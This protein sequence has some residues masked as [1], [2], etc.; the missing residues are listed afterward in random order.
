ML[1]VITKLITN[2][3]K[4]PEM[5]NPLSIEKL[6]GVQLINRHAVIT[7]A[8]SPAIDAG[9][10]LTNT[11]SSGSGTVIT[12]DDAG[13]F[14]DGFDIVDG[15]SIQLE[16]QT[17]TARITNVNYATNT[18][19]LATS[20]TWTSGQGVSLPYEGSAPDIGAYEYTD[21]DDGGDEKISIIYQ[22]EI[23]GLL[24]SKYII[25]DCLI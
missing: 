19:T 1:W 10:F 21:S 12:V 25:N 3:S 4:R 7:E 15:D 11:A 24:Y 13:Y 16:G 2:A 9:R 14:F 8:T 17:Q 6:K 23:A 5:I 20:L 22:K 18:L